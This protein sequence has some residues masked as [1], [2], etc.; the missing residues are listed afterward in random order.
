MIRV[1][2][3]TRIFLRALGLLTVLILA[4]TLASGASS[5]IHRRE[6]AQTIYQGQVRTLIFQM[7][8]L[9]LWDDRVALDKLITEVVEKDSTLGY[10]FL[11]RGGKPYVYTFS[12]GVPKALLGLGPFSMEQATMTPFR[13]QEGGQWLDIAQAV[14]AD[15]AVLHLGVNVDVLFWQALVGLRGVLVASGAALLAGAL[16]AWYIARATTREV[17]AD[18]EALR[19]SMAFQNS[20]L[21]AMPIPVFYKDREGRYLG[22][23]RAYETF[24]GATNDQLIGKTVFDI[25][26]R[27]LAEIYRVKDNELFESGGI[28]QYES[29]VKNTHGV[30]RDVIF[31]KAVFF[32]ARGAVGG[33][34]GAILDITERKRAEEAFQQVNRRNQMILESAGEGIFGLDSEARIDFINPAAL[35]I[36][37]FKKDELLGQDSHAALHHSKPDGSSYR[38]E[39]CPIHHSVLSELGVRG[40]EETFWRKDGSPLPVLFSSMPIKEDGKVIGAVVT[41]QDITELKQKEMALEESEERLHTATET[42]RDAMVIIEGER[43]TITVWNPAAE[44]IFGHT[45][46]EALGQSLHELLAPSRFRETAQRGLSHFSS[47]GEGGAV[48]KTLELVALRKDGT[49]FPIELSLSAMQICGKWHAT[50]FVRDIT[51]R[52][53]MEQ[54]RLTH[55]Q[56]VESLDRINRAIQETNDLEKT[57]SDVLGAVLAIFD[58]DRAWLFYPCDP[59]APSFR[60]PMEIAKPEY[61]GAGILNVDVPMPPD[62]AQNLREA[63]ESADP[64]TY[65]VGTDRPINKVSA[66]QFGVKSM[67]M[68]ALYPQSGKAWAFGLHQCAYPRVWTA[69]DKR[70]FQ[71]ISRRLGDSLTGLLSHRDLQESEAK[72]RRIVDT[73]NEGIWMLG[74]DT[75]TTFV[76][77]RMAGM[78]GYSGEEMIGRPVT[79]FMFGEDASDHLRKMEHRRQGISDNYER[80]YR[81]KDGQAVWTLASAAP[82][83]DGKHQ[84]MGSFAMFTDITERKQAEERL[85]RA[86]TELERQAMA[87]TRTNADLQRFAEVTA[88]HLKEPARRLATYAMRLTKQLGDRLDDAEARLS[89]E[90]IN[91]QARQQQALL[92]DVERYLASDQPRG[93]IESIDAYQTVA[94]ILARLKNRIREAG[95]EIS[96]GNLPP[97]RIDLPRLDDAFSIALDNALIHGRC[98]HPLCIGIEGEHQGGKVRYSISDNGPGV[99]AQYRERVFRV[100][101]RLTSDDHVIGTGI[102]LAILRRI[103]ESCDGRAWI[104]ETPGGGCRVLFELPI[105]E[106]H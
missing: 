80:R 84:F 6:Y 85:K 24:F 73:A 96:L 34:I 31:N 53:R 54:E 21:D 42:A 75:M 33:L 17:T 74:P 82:I 64:V 49:E 91:Q 36:L 72:Y 44:T 43:G 30:L 63:L 106:S 1:D 97:S 22:C 27:E 20:L 93:E 39:D 87:L 13:D 3:R 90:F 5:V 15:A 2:L 9:V 92:R 23:N 25:S 78:L 14:P 71:E 32:D 105:G 86:N 28:Q 37:G 81:R 99:E 4:V 57:L 68:A 52:K 41:F 51:E 103:A 65:I 88:H 26:P 40:L 101:E 79:D 102:G 98:A 76:N 16:F 55:L 69:E 46:A 7:T 89:L 83:F 19:E 100:F 38:Q 47:S 35:T 104:E 62:M 60:V 94:R 50:G 77:A 61:P 11:E 18:E 66:E 45:R 10:V 48:G 95:A 58:C 70:L 59:D 56:F 12:A 67:M 29:Q 8:E